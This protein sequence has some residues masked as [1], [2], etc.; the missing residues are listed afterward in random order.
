MKDIEQTLEAL[1]RAISHCDY[2]HQTFAS[3]FR[4]GFKDDMLVLQSLRDAIPALIADA[5]TL[6]KMKEGGPVAFDWMHE[7]SRA[8]GLCADDYA[9]Q[10]GTALY[11]LPDEVT[12]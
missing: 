7:F 9:R 2:A 1:D 11:T 10:F 5:E 4:S 6:R 3:D 8:D 12:K